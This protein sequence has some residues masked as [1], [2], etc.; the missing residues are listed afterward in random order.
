M[1]HFL[2]LPANIQ[3]IKSL[4]T[5]FYCFCTL[6]NYDLRDKY[7][8]LYMWHNYALFKLNQFANRIHFVTQSLAHL[9]SLFA[10]GR[11]NYAIINMSC[12]FVSFLLANI[13]NFASK[14]DNLKHRERFQLIM[15]KANS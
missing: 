12:K 14:T 9:H 10:I 6:E 15:L 4:Q 13:A 5:I 8:Y 1:V 7:A 2:G 11:V 3:N